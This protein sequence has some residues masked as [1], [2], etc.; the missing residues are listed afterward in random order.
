M[1]LFTFGGTAR[2]PK[3]YDAGN[4]ASFNKFCSSAASRNL[5]KIVHIFV[6]LNKSIKLCVCLFCVGFKLHLCLHVTA[7]HCFVLLHC[8]SHRFPRIV[9]SNIL[10]FFF[11]FSQLCE[12]FVTLLLCLCLFSIY[13]FCFRLRS[14][15]RISIVLAVRGGVCVSLRV[16]YEI[17]VAVSSQ[18][19]FYWLIW[20]IN[21][22]DRYK[23]VWR[24]FFARSVF[25]CISVVFIRY[26]C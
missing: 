1:F 7:C 24:L 5:K 11:F 9:Y 26:A 14:S 20:V 21:L 2:Q 3:P 25:V 6:F 16:S 17:V 13:K 12:H 22:N 15:W 23:Q 18:S 8:S 4:T 19:S 10:F